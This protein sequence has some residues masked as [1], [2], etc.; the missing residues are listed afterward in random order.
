MPERLDHVSVATARGPVQ[1]PWQARAG[2]L[3]RHRMDGF[4][5]E[6]LPARSSFTAREAPTAWKAPTTERSWSKRVPSP[7]TSQNG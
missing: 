4:E 1:I 5:D 3:L 7:G 2:C 6:A